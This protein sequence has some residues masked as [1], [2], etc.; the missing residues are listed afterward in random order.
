MR[1][2]RDRRQWTQADLA[3]RMTDR[4][5]PTD[6][7]TIAKIETGG[8]RAAN[9]SIAELLVIAAALGVAPIHLIAPREADEGLDVGTLSLSADDARGWIRG[10]LLLEDSD[11]RAFFAEMSEREQRALVRGMLTEGIDP[12]LSALTDFDP[13]RQVDEVMPW[14]R[15]RI[16]DQLWKKKG[17][18]QKE[19]DDG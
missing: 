11:P 6:R 9:V 1:E 12:L 2:A 14:L 8:T 13:D 15:E 18:N 5:R 16:D 19:G 4:G 3:Q 7:T 10:L 17:N